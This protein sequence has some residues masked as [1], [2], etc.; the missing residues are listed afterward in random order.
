MHSN[1]TF[2]ATREGEKPDCR[3]RDGIGAIRLHLLQRAAKSGKL[4]RRGIAAPLRPPQLDPERWVVHPQPA[5][6]GAEDY[7]RIP[8]RRKQLQPPTSS[9]RLGTRPGAGTR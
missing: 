3:E 4:V 6:R 5:A 8:D 7:E 1:G 2:A 9:D